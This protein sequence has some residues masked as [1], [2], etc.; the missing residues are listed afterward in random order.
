MPLR[1]R[2]P[3][4]GAYTTMNSQSA[5]RPRAAD[6]VMTVQDELQQQV[7]QACEAVAAAADLA[8]LDQVRVHYLGKK[9]VLTERMKQL[10]QLAPEDRPR[11]GG[12][13]QHRQGAGAAG[14]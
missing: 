9:G 11:V 1:P 3:G 14:D 4:S 12:I 10:G 5:T 6:G 13:D 8:A 2:T 7:T